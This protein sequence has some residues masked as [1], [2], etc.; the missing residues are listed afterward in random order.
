MVDRY[1]F[2]RNKRGI[3]PKKVTSI[4]A[5]ISSQ[6]DEESE[7]AGPRN[8]IKKNKTFAED[9]IPVESSP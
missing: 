9:K 4:P 7:I 5:H 8:I 2:P 6:L 1:L 3:S